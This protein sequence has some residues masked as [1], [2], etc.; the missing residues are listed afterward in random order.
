LDEAFRYPLHVGDCWV[1]DTNWS[2][3]YYPDASDTV[4]T[5]VFPSHSTVEVIRTDTLLQSMPV[6][7]FQEILYEQLYQRSFQSISFYNSQSDGFFLYAYRLP[8]NDKVLPKGSYPTARSFRYHLSTT[9]L[10]MIEPIWGRTVG[11]STVT[12]SLIFENPP[13]QVLPYPIGPG[14]QWKVRRFDGSF[15]L[16]KRVISKELVTV[17]AGDFECYKIQWL[18]D[19]DGDGKWDEDVIAY[20]YISDQ[21]LIRRIWKWRNNT[22]TGAAGDTLGTFED[23]TESL[24]TL[25][26]RPSNKRF[27]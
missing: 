14:L 19:M 12:D 23:I 8:P 26:F 6:Y 9:M 18:Y 17:P 13:V 15:R 22:W 24:L 2:F 1:Y 20:D 3:Y 21:G 25:R 27:E 11:T 10:P 5:E 16:D 7:V 4:L